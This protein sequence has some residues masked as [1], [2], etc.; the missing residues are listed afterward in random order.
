MKKGIWINSILIGISLGLALLTKGTAYLYGLPF[1]IW[2][3]FSGRQKLGVQLLKVLFAVPLIIL[4]LNLGH[5]LRNQD[6]YGSPLAPASEMSFYPNQ[7]LSPAIGISNVLRNM[8]LHLA[9]PF[10]SINARIENAVSKLHSILSLDIND[11]RSTDVRSTSPP[12]KRF[13][14]DTDQTH[15][16]HAG[17][18]IHLLLICLG[19]GTLMIAAGLR[20]SSLL[21]G[22]ALSLVAGFL[23]FCLYIRWMVWNSRLHLPLFVLWSPFVAVAISKTSLV[24]LRTYVIIFL[25]IASQFWLFHN[26]T[27]PLIGM[28]IGNIFAVPR[29]DQYFRHRPFLQY[30]YEHVAKLLRGQ[31]CSRI[32]LWAQGWSFEY[33][34]WVLLDFSD[35]HQLRIEHINVKNESANKS[36]RDRFSN[37]SP[38]A[39]L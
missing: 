10:A 3:A 22:Y 27:R 39:I 38:C 31:S 37:F 24:R 21:P 25:V 11:A 29:L 14:L 28:G 13:R 15:E 16:D 8:A 26:K 35:N 33:P 20:H 7:T 32:G 18:P 4:I 17:N 30:P 12:G 9:T 6:L 23:I 1:F 2:L 19:L 5:Y 36:S 34:L